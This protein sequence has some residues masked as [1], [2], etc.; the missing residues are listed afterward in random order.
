MAG[1][2]TE[3]IDVLDAEGEHYEDLLGLAKEKKEILVQN[4]VESLK[5]ITS[6]ENTLISRI[7]RL[8]KK[9]LALMGDIATVLGRGAKALT[10][11][12]LMETVRGQNE[13]PALNAAAGRLRAAAG[14]L[15]EINALNKT[16]VEQSLEYIDFALNLLRGSANSGPS[17][18]G[19]GLDDIDD[20][21]QFFDAR[22]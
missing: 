6:L 19:N 4:D 12:A 14:S 3:L 9:R 8:E 21:A 13:Y 20:G 2:L 11:G 7:N 15:R 22:Q 5:K 18:Y 17:F 10:L 16:L 1:L